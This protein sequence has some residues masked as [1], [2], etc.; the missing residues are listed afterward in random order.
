MDHKVWGLVLA[1]AGVA[2]V[3]GYLIGVQQG[4]KQ[5]AK[6]PADMESRVGGMLP[7]GAQLPVNH[8]PIE[9]TASPAGGAAIPTGDSKFTHF[10]V[11]NRNVKSLFVDGDVIW[12]GTSGG[13]IRYDTRDDSHQ[14]YDNRVPGI[15]SNGIF[16]VSRIGDHILAG[17]Y[18]GGLSVFDLKSQE[19]KNYNIPQG[20]ADQ[21]VYAPHPIPHP[22]RCSH[23]TP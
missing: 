17:T 19:W 4:E 8:P 16:H 9:G 18:G 22:N 14:V 7:P 12:I 1:G 23:E 11:G 6:R 15:L 20:L 13:V 2:V 3:A 5:V 21:F 10:R